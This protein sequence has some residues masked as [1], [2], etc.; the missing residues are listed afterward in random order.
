MLPPSSDIEKLIALFS[1]DKKAVEKISFVLDG[2]KGIELV[3]IDDKVI[4][5]KAMEALL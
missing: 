5:K 3:E 2:P 4:L 1:R